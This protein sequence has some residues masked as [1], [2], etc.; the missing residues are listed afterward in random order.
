MMEIG[1]AIVDAGLSEL[2]RSGIPK[3]QMKKLYQPTAQEKSDADSWCCTQL[4]SDELIRR[5]GRAPRESTRSG[6][7]GGRG[8]NGGQWGRTPRW[9]K[10]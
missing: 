9:A 4:A 8:W 6:A 10:G 3:N 1:A 5:S 2:I 7:R